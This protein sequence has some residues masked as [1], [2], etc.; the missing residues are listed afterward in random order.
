MEN[1]KKNNTVKN[2]Y[3]KDAKDQEY[4]GYEHE[5]GPLTA[6]DNALGLTELDD[7]IASNSTF[8]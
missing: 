1:R 4:Y 6:L 5:P 8:Q 2:L 3:K 7:A